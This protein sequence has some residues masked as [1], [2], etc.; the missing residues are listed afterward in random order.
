MDNDRKKQKLEQQIARMMED[1]DIDEIERKNQLDELIA[2]QKETSKPQE[3][4]QYSHTN[5]PVLQETNDNQKTLKFSFKFDL[6][7]SCKPLQ[8]NSVIK[9]I[10]R[11]KEYFSIAFYLNRSN[12]AR[13]QMYF[14]YLTENER[15][16]YTIPS[17]YET[18]KMIEAS[19]YLKRVRNERIF[20]C[21]IHQF[22]EN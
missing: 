9:E 12:P 7:V 18:S 16:S 1:P 22:D 6:K 3:V 5:F 15:D 10:I 13:S 17:L 8:D 21:L 4:K 2:L 20:R 19:D 11:L 14:S